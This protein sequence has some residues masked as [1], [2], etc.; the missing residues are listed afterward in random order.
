MA[1]PWVPQGIV[2]VGSIM[3][4]GK[5]PELA[6]GV[7]GYVIVA[8]GVY[9]IPVVAAVTPGNG[10]VSRWLNTLP[11]NLAISF[12]TVVNERFAKMLRKRGFSYD[13]KYEGYARK[14]EKGDATC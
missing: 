10:D 2:E 8:D 5:E 14:A 9:Y 12:P 1:E 6:P 13:E 3:E 11:R 7:Q 4:P